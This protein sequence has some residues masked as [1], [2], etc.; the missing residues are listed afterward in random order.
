MKNFFLFVLVSLICIHLTTNLCFTN[1]LSSA[2][3]ESEKIEDLKEKIE[4]FSELVE[5][6]QNNDSSR[7]VKKIIEIIKSFHET[8]F[9]SPDEETRETFKI[10]LSKATS[11]KKIKGLD[12]L[13]DLNKILKSYDQPTTIN[14]MPQEPKRESEKTTEETSDLVNKKIR[15]LKSASEIHKALTLRKIDRQLEKL[16]F[17]VEENQKSIARLLELNVTPSHQSEQTNH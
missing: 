11:N 1:Q 5:F 13:N 6:I 14:E 16:F 4:Y 12:Y 15:K 7:L 17:K 3:Y 2:I 10:L 8:C 9:Y